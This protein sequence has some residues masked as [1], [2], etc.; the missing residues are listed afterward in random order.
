MTRYKPNV[1][2]GGRA[3]NIKGNLYYMSGRKHEAGGIDIGK[4][5]RT[6]LE[7][8]D[9]EVV[10]TSSNGLKVFSAQPILNGNSPAKLVMGGANP[11][12]IFNAQERFKEINGIND[13]GTKKKRN[14]R[15]IT[16][17]K[18]L[19]GLSRKKDYGSDKKPYPSV[20]SNDFAGGGRSYPIPTKADARDALRLAGLHGRSDVKAKVYKKYPELKNK[21]HN[22]EIIYRCHNFI[23]SDP[24]WKECETEVIH[25]YSFETI[26][27]AL[28][29][30]FLKMLELG[31]K[32]RKCTVCGKYFIITGH[33]GKCCDNLY[34][35]TGLTCQQVFADRNY[36]NKRKKNPV[37]KEYDKAYKRMY[38]RYSSKKNLTSDEYAKWKNEA[39]QERD[40]A[41]KAYA[42]NPSD[43][44]INN[45]KQF[46]NNK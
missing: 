36:K 31:I 38:A 12:K 18:K 19:G 7:V 34:K 29:C 28:L 6:G 5:P 44:V 27:E 14:M 32:I 35:D 23:E 3:T 40:K 1:I 26:S 25:G 42:E 9:G 20:K 22:P 17:K 13:D 41:L 2:R 15:T 11:A 33:N 8:E 21:T 46:L 24:R 45:F 39:A 10:Q 37:L 43:T 16:G 30:E 4:N